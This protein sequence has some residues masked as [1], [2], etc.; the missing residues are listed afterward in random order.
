MFNHNT[1]AGFSTVLPTLA[2]DPFAEIH[3]R[4]A[5]A[6]GIA[7]GDPVVVESP[8]GQLDLEAKV[9]TG[10]PPGCVFVPSG[11]NEA[12]VNTLLAGS[13]IVGVRIRKA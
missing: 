10:T 2:P 5:T 4:D 1:M 6:H 7:D 13:A 11:Y 3:P 12:P 8:H 9:T